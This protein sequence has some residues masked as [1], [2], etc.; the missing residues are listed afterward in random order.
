MAHRWVRLSS[1]LPS[2]GGVSNTIYG[3]RIRRQSTLL[4]R[5]GPP[6]SGKVAARQICLQSFKSDAELCAGYPERLLVYHG[7]VGR[8]VFLGCLKVTTM[9]LFVAS[10]SVL[11]PHFYSEDLAPRWMP[12][13][14]MSQHSKFFYFS[15]ECFLAIAFGAIPFAFVNHTTRPFVSFVHIALPVFARR[16]KESLY[17]WAQNIPPATQVYMTTTRFYGGPRVSRMAV[18]DLR[19]TRAWLSAA[20]LTRTPPSRSA[21]A[22]KSWRAPKPL[23][24]FYVGTEKKKAKDFSVWEQV[25]KRIPKEAARTVF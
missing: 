24:R 13:A 7:G 22:K 20:N 25:L 5:N 1:Q 23:L 16:S 8:T 2:L 21:A 11:A 17:R 4:Y 12:V 10:C 9:V 19:Q 14:G 18:E 3:I 15:P 6:K